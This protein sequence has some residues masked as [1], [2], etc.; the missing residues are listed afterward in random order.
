MNIRTKI[1]LKVSK[2]DK[3][4]SKMHTGED[5]VLQKA[6]KVGTDITQ[7]EVPEDRRAMAENAILLD[8][9]PPQWNSWTTVCPFCLGG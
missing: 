7:E 6:K 4:G 5:G 2:D 3:K 9:P 1:A 8:S